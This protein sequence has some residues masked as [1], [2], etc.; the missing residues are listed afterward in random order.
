MPDAPNV[1]LINLLIGV[2]LAG[3]MTRYW[4]LE[5]GGRSLPFWIVGAWVLTAADLFF[6]LRAL[7]PDQVPRPLPTIVVTLGH[8]ALWLAARRFVVHP[9]ATARTETAWQR[10]AAGIVATHLTLLVV[11]TELPALA[12][13]RTVANGVVWGGLSF[14]AAWTL[15]RAERDGE[16]AMVAPALVLAFQGG[17]HVVRTALAT[18]VVVGSDM[19]SSPLVQ[20]IGDLE[21]SLFMVALFV[22][23]L[24]S[25]LQ[26]SHRE[27]RAAMESVW[28][29]SGMLPLCAWCHK[30]RDDAGY[31]T[32]IE[33]YLHK[34][35]ITVTHA[36][37]DDCARDH[38]DATDHAAG[39]PAPQ[40]VPAT[41]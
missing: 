16:R 3:A 2:L 23:V 34:H 28:Q 17:F 33:E 31:W 5:A 41:P 14:V 39:P 15:W 4:R 9:S 40:G 26:Q 10:L 27:L 21:V 6:L 20:I 30:V 38:F 35:Q 7:A 29:L 8:V 11:F 36:M 18:R 13:W 12:P 1:Y 32:R 37:C 24:V 25:F 22:S 19:G